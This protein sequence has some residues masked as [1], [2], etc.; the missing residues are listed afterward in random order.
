MEKV[1]LFVCHGNIC[2][3]PAAEFIFKYLIQKNDIKGFACFSRGVSF[4][5]EGNDIYPPM[6]IALNAKK[7][8]FSKH[9]AHKISDEDYKK[10]NYIFCMDNSNY[11]LLTKRFGKDKIY[12]LNEFV[13]EKNI[14]L[15]PWYSGEFQ[16][17]VNQLYFYIEKLIDKLTK[18]A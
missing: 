2:R 15:D 3:S 7:I 10:A 17:V 13:F 14:V 1:I 9:E 16:N 6:K 18:C 4:E 11:S 5:E 8:P 12:L